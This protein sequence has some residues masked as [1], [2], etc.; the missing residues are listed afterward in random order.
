[1]SNTEENNYSLAT[2]QNV[3]EKSLDG[4]VPPVHAEQFEAQRDDEDSANVSTSTQASDAD[5]DVNRYAYLAHMHL[6]L[7]P[8]CPSESRLPL[9]QRKKNLK[10][11]KTIL[12]MYSE[13]H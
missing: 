6:A 3:A 11:K 12:K 5:S 13:L 4:E 10:R 2:S 7:L 8:K 1:M 9:I